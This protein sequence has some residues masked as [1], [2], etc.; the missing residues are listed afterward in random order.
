MLFDLQFWH[1]WKMADVKR[2]RRTVCLSDLC[3]LSR[4]WEWL[5]EIRQQEEQRFLNG[6]HE[7]KGFVTC[8]EGAEHSGH[9][10]QATQMNM[11]I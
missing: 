1:T 5:L 6:F 9:H 11:C 7:F 10:Q 3:K 4:C 8:V 2:L